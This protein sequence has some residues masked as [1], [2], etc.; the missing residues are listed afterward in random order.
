MAIMSALSGRLLE[1]LAFICLAVAW[2]LCGCWSFV[3]VVCLFGCVGVVFVLCFAS[4]EIFESSLYN[5]Q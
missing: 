3:G 2:L 1:N 4:R 5:F